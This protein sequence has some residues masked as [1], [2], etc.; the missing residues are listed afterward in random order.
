MLAPVF[1]PEANPV[2]A[3]PIEAKVPAPAPAVV[4]VPAPDPAPAAAPAPA[5]APGDVP[6]A[7][8]TFPTASG[9]FTLKEPL[10]QDIDPGLIVSPDFSILLLD[11]IFK[12]LFIY[13]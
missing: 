6:G 12:G 2:V 9:L 1:A 5:P 8:D 11:C 3:A 13:P 7:N 10:P 4:P